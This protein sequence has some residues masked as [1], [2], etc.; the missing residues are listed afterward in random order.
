MRMLFL[1]TACTA[2]AAPGVKWGDIPLSF[3]PNTGQEPAEVRYLARGSSYTLYLAGE[4]TV[5]AGHNQTPLL[6]KLL[7]AN[8]SAGI[9]GED[10]QASTSNYFVGKDPSK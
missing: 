10:Q 8:P 9:A 5:L 2:M 3:E 6:T 4:E 7:G 1:F